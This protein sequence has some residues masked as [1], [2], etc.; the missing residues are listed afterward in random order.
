[1]LNE[2]FKSESDYVFIVSIFVMFIHIYSQVFFMVYINQVW[3]II[4]LSSAWFCIQNYWVDWIH[5]LILGHFIKGD[6]VSGFL[7][8]FCPPQTFLKGVYSK[9]KAFVP[10]GTNPFHLEKNPF[11]NGDK[12]IMI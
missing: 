5:M 7:L 2:Q 6:N 12:T 9:W 3:I 8:L 11:Q 10:K 1:M 4:I